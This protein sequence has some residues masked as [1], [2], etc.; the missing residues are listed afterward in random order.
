M[1]IV[2][3][4][5]VTRPGDDIIIRPLNPPLIRT[6]ALI[7]HRNKP[8]DLAFQIVRDALMEIANIPESGGKKRRH[9][10]RSP[11]AGRALRTLRA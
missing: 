5:A 4:I 10:Q 2:P 11:D 6:L 8:E 3:A 7:H 9:R 1:A